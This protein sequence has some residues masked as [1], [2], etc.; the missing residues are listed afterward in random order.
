MNEEIKLDLKDR[1]ILF[2]LDTNARQTNSQIAR[3]VGLNK[4]TVNYKITRM[5]KEGIILGYYSVIDS[6]KVGYFSVR[7]YARFL[8][9]S[10]NEEKRILNWLCNSKFVGVVNKIETIYD[11]GFMAYVKSIYEWEEVWNEFKRKFRKYFWQEQVDIFSK[12][13]H[14]KRKYLLGKKDKPSNFETIGGREIEK[15]DN[16]DLK[17]LSLLAQN[18]RI[19]LVDLSFKLKIPVRT[20]ASRIKNLEKRKIIQGYRLDLNLVK[21]GYEYYKLNFKLNDC[22]K[23]QELFNFCENHINVIYIDQTLGDFDF[24]IDVEVMN[25]TELLELINYIKA[26]F[27]VRELEFL[28]FKEYLKLET[29]PRF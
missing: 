16:T 18:A 22:S 21:I 4:N 27:E 23:Y 11:F 1:K 15:V 6:S 28:F 17:I 2:E 12:V 29:I 14:Y 26:K 10:E 24:E 5:T 19:S 13:Y 25:R 8:N 3:K 7:V 9:T 20:L